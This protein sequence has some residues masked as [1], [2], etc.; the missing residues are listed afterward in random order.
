MIESSL[1]RESKLFLIDKGSYFILFES[2]IYEIVANRKG[3]VIK[4][5]CTVDEF[6][7]L[8]YYLA[9]F[10]S[11]EAGYEIL[12]VERDFPDIGIPL[13][14]FGVFAK[15]RIVEIP[16]SYRRDFS[17]LNVVPSLSLE[18]YVE[19]V[20]RIKEYIKEGYSYQVNFTFKVFFE[21]E[22]DPLSLFLE[23]RRKQRVKYG[24]FVK[25]GDGYILS[26]SPEL[27]FRTRG[28]RITTKPMKGTIGRG[29][30]IEEDRVM[31]RKLFRSEKNRAEN[32]MIVDLLRNDISKVS[33]NGCVFVDRMFEVEK[34]ETVFQMT[35][36]VTGILRSDVKFSD[37]VKG[38]FPGGS[39]TGAPKRKT[40]EIIAEVENLPRGI[41]TGAIGYILPNGDSEF[42][43]AIRTPFILGRRGE[44]G[45]GS[46][47]TWY[48]EPFEEY[49]ECFLKSR[50][51]TSTPPK[52]FKLVE[53]MLVRNGKIYLLKYHLRRLKRSAKFFSFRFDERVVM[54]KLEMVKGMD[55]KFKV[56]LLLDEVGRVYVEVFKLSGF[57][58]S[59]YIKLAEDRT[60]SRNVF[61]YHKTTNRGLY[62][63]YYKRA[64]EE[65]VVDYVFLNENGH[66]TEGTVH[67]IILLKGEELVT[68]SRECGL[69]WGTMLEYLTQKY[70]IREDLVSVDDLL[71][72]RGV[73]LCN[74]VSGIK[75]VKLLFGEGR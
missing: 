46:G 52:P 57:S 28:N 12:G 50:F 8:G 34:Y 16:Y 72:A 20:R 21:F 63:I 32:L 47:V 36:T 33:E 42:N 38:L 74:S 10:I 75:R 54:E 62:D 64:K 18:E 23:L 30:F 60:D 4:A 1:K 59:G 15:P 26:V 71:G 67:N 11:F 29:R 48:S 3:E 39:V 5:L 40:L 7:R 27:F 44:M 2:P 68:P 24:R 51:L 14:W 41:Y 55:G 49:N 35:S 65:K 19:V 17:V 73:F 53:T 45:I 66:V 6:T 58:K 25:C 13:V 43:M 37:V 70:R 9:G 61:L 22:G 69:L 31:E 56:R